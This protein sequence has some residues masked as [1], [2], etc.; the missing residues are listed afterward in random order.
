MTGI[1]FLGAGNMAGSMVDGLLRAGTPP[2]SLACLGG[3]GSTATALVARTGIRLATGAG[4]LCRGAGVLVVAF[5]PK[6]LPIAGPAFAEASR[7][8]LVVSILA[9]RT[10]ASLAAAFPGARA[11]VRAM[12]NTP[13]RIGAGISAWCTDRPLTDHDRALVARIL[14]ALGEVHEVPEALMDAVT[15]VGGSGPGFVFEFTAALR[16]AAVEAGFPEGL[17]D[18][19]ARSVVAGSGRL[20]EGG[21][22]P[23][24]LRDQVT[25]PAGT[26][27]AGL[28]VLRNAA[29]RRIIRD[30]VLAATRRGGELARD[31]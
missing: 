22:D 15:A 28:E 4:E 1:A 24:A 3:A 26:T 16:A 9:G 19:F 6:H 8:I 23:D 5:K 27:A 14:G 7:G 29:F 30:A 18:A 2:A 17:A 31:S 20:L 25:S 10:L 12:P 21:G 11:I 13:G